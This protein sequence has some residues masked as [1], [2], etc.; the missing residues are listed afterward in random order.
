ML[1]KEYNGYRVSN[2][3]LVTKRYS[4]ELQKTKQHKRGYVLAHIVENGTKKWMLVHRLVAM[5]FI[6]NPENKPQV[7]HI[8]GDKTNNC[9]ENLEWVTNSE[10]RE[11]AVE[12][13]LIAKGDRLSKKLTSEMAEAIRQEYIPR[14][15]D[16]NQYSLAAKYG[17]SQALIMKII[18]G[19]CWKV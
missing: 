2:T 16:R 9:V 13:N 17:V 3:G 10:N 7:N 18:N 6:P 12:N 4:N 1:W 8:D 11:H 15:K 19:K 14:S 5:L